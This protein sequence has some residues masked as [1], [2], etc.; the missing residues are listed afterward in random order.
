MRTSQRKL[1]CDVAA[2][3]PSLGRAAR[4]QMWRLW[5]DDTP[6]LGPVPE[7][8]G[9]DAERVSRLVQA[10]FPRW[11]HLSVTPVAHGGW[12]NWT[13]RLGPD[14]VVRLPS[15]AEYALAVPKEQQW[16]P[17][18]APSLPLP[19][20][21]PL[22]LGRPTPNYPQPCR[23]PQE[24]GVRPLVLQHNPDVVAVVGK[25]IDLRKQCVRM[26]DRQTSAGET[27]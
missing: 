21:V 5:V 26:T 9:I 14:M 15:A 16:L 24:A 12:D 25:R 17:I 22:A 3:C 11:A 19:I 27:R 23:R 6:G 1:R 10:Q 20:P 8:L 18:L 4:R 2:G 13:F 7:R